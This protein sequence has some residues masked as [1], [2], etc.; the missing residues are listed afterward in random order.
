MKAHLLLTVSLLTI[1]AAHATPTCQPNPD[2][3][4][5]C[6]SD[7]VALPPPE[8]PE[9]IM[10]EA[11]GSTL[12]IAESRFE[13]ACQIYRECA[14]FEGA[15]KC[16]GYLLQNEIPPETEPLPACAGKPTLSNPMIVNLQPSGNPNLIDADGRDVELR[17]PAVPVTDDAIEI[18]DARH[19]V[20]IAGHFKP[21]GNSD[22][23]TAFKLL[24]QRTGGVAYLERMLIDIT[25]R[26]YQNDYM[27]SDP[28]TIQ[29]VHNTGDAIQFGGQVPYNAGLQT[30]YPSFILN[31]AIIKGVSGQDP[32]GCTTCGGAH[33]DGFETVGPSA[34]VSFKDAHFFSN[35]Q[36]IFAAP[37]LNFY[38]QYLEPHE[39]N[40]NG[41]SFENVT[42][43]V[44]KPPNLSSADLTKWRYRAVGY[45]LEGY[46]LRAEGKQSYWD[47]SVDSGGL[48][49]DTPASET[50]NWLNFIGGKT[51]LHT[52]VTPATTP[53]SATF[54][55]G[56]TPFDYI[57]GATLWNGVSPNAPTLAEVGPASSPICE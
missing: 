29:S 14:A 5:A 7:L 18:R 4:W 35:Y 36:G 8:P 12:P 37:A 53:K 20:S 3:T 52:E 31:T 17:W 56:G 45:Y 50:Q 57:P 19:I 44:V 24:S 27:H 54:T 21:T 15:F 41:V 26:R 25:D 16:T 55:S 42:A 34:S 9:Q 48:W 32:Q 10:C 22:N 47:L 39:Q 30:T 43:T 33:A 40:L 49:L 2:G 28:D 11:T 46:N 38:G 1:T 6:T 13:E 51:V 23:N